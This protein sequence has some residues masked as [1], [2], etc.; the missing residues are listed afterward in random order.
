VAATGKSAMVLSGS[1]SAKSSL[2]MSCQYP[3]STP[4]MAVAPFS[5]TA[6]Y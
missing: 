1:T 6:P 4:V 5:V 3:L 2:V